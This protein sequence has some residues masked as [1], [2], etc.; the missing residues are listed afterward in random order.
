LTQTSV[1]F[2]D[3]VKTFQR[4]FQSSEFGVSFGLAKAEEADSHKRITMPEGR[5]QQYHCAIV[6]L[7]DK[8]G[9]LSETLGV[10]QGNRNNPGRQGFPGDILRSKKQIVP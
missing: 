9:G 10:L 7:R 2:R 5:T 1:G 6:V 3:Y 4:S 8:G